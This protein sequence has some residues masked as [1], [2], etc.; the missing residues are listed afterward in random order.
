M[1][2]INPARVLNATALAFPMLT[3]SGI[4]ADAIMVNMALAA[5]P[6]TT[7]AD[8]GVFSLVQLGNC[9]IN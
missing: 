4:M 2:D 1:D 3:A 6:S 7:K 5:I 9:K 8:S